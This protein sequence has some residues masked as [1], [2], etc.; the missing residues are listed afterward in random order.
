MPDRSKDTV[1]D[2]FGLCSYADPA[3]A[4]KEMQR[5]CKPDGE[6]LLLEHG[7]SAY[8]LVTRYLDWAAPAHAQR[9]GCWFN[10]PIEKMIADSG[11]EITSV[12]RTGLGTFYAIVAKP[13][14]QLPQK[15][16]N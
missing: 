11:M 4:L 10:R 15:N 6:V 9:W 5:V 8:S 7:A 13:G 14:P 3:R 16:S 2:S 1:V 12:E